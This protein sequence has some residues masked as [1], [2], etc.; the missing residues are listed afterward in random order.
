MYQRKKKKKKKKKIRT[1]HADSVACTMLARL[2]H[3]VSVLSACAMRTQYRAARETPPHGPGRPVGPRARALNIESRIHIRVR[4]VRELK[5][6][7]RCA[8]QLA[9]IEE[10]WF[11]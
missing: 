9:L 6:I 11:Q 2:Q 10:L 5:V 3:S 1:V 4:G 8:A 7:A